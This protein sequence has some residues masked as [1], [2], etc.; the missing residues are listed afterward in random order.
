M[1][2][3]QRTKQ[4]VRSFGTTFFMVTLEHWLPVT[5]LPIMD[6]ISQL[7]AFIVDNISMPIKYY[8]LVLK[9]E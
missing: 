9:A 1:I 5:F 6:K 2:L 4:E 8:K 3:L 7:E